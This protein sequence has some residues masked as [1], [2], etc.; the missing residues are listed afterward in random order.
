MTTEGPKRT[1]ALLVDDS[2]E[3]LDVAS[4]MLRSSGYEVVTASSF[5]QA[6]ERL[7]SGAVRLL[8]TDI[9]LREFNGLQLAIEASLKGGV[10]IVIITG[11]EDSS[12]EAQAAQIRAALCKKPFTHES[13]EAAIKTAAR[14]P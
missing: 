1:V 3:V 13:L 2:P 6:R 12:L 4:R 5:E 11:W 7:R 9:R 14:L 8:V 10:D